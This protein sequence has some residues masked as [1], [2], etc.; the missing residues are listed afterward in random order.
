MIGTRFPIKGFKEGL[1]IKLG[2]GPWKEVQASLLDQIEERI[3]FFNGAKIALD[4][5]ERIIR[6]ADMGALRDRLSDRGVSLFAIISK[7]NITDAAA[8]SLGLSTHQTVLREKDQSVRNALAD[9]E[10]AVLIRKTLRS[11]MSIKY[12]GHVIFEG[13]VYS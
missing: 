4:V 11:G 5:D 8:E 10:N 7:S 3:D 9:G 6:A 1:L 13:D 2:S 12:P